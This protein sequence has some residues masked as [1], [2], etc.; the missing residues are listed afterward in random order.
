MSTLLFL[1]RLPHQFIYTY[2]PTA[3]ASSLSIPG[4]ISPHPAPQ[5]VDYTNCSVHGATPFPAAISVGRTL[6]PSA[7]IYPVSNSG[8]LSSE[9]SAGTTRQPFLGLYTTM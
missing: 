2:L 6:D 5:L 8:Y 7:A 9:I 4:L 3:T 1:S